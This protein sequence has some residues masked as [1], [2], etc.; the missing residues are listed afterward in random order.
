MQPL[1]LKVSDSFADWCEANA[2]SIAQAAK[3]MISPFCEP[4]SER[5]FYADIL[6]QF[7]TEYSGHILETLVKSEEKPGGLTPAE[8]I[9]IICGCLEW[10]YCDVDDC[11]RW[12]G[13]DYTVDDSPS[14]VDAARERAET[15]LF[16]GHA[17]S[18][19]C[20]SSCFEIYM[21][22]EFEQWADDEHKTERY[23]EEESGLWR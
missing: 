18:T 22:P 1:T 2:E 16:E 9:A 21:R 17:D 4:G 8:K 11:C 3:E 15:L 5:T 23:L 20:C 12:I 10:R 14:P 19:Y 6:Y 13:P 7:Q